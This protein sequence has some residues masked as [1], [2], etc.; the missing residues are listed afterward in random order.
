MNVRVSIAFLLL[1]LAAACGCGSN[2]LEGP[3][4]LRLGRDECGECGMLVGEDRFSSALLVDRRGL[5][6]HI[7]YDDI[8]CMLDA[9]VEHQ[10]EWKVIERFVHD[11]A[12]RA[13]LPAGRASFLFADSASLQTPMGSGIAAYSDKAA[14]E[15]DRER[16]GGRVLGLDE[17]A[18]ARK[19]WKKARLS[20]PAPEAGR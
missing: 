1:C 15:R 18:E 8:G 17:L 5:R 7:V 9:E 19:A 11:R 10:S 6:E 4:E 16:H 12:T 2:E 14:A 20:P 3:P 13:W